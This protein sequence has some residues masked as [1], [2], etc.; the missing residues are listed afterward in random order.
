MPGTL[1]LASSSKKPKTLD[2]KKRAIQAKVR[3]NSDTIK[4]LV[5]TVEALDHLLYQSARQIFKNSS[6]DKPQLIAL[7]KFCYLRSNGAQKWGGSVF[8]PS[9]I[10]G[11]MA[12]QLHQEIIHVARMI[13]P[14]EGGV[15]S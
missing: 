7:L 10:D 6:L 15:N 13:V 5:K 3:I 4:I 14:P 8:E 12:E 11:K 2:Q 1:R 9:A